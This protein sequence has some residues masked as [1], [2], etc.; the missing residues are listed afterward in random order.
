MG[1]NCGGDVAGLRPLTC[2][3]VVEWLRPRTTISFFSFVTLLGR[4]LG[5]GRRIFLVLLLL[6]LG[7]EFKAVMSLWSLGV[8]P[9]PP[10]S[11]ARLPL[12]PQG[13][14]FHAFI[15]ATCSLLLKFRHW[16]PRHCLSALAVRNAACNKTNGQGCH[17]DQA[18]TFPGIGP[19]C[20]ATSKSNS[21]NMRF[22]L[23]PSSPWHERSHSKVVHHGRFA[24]TRA[25]SKMSAPK[26][27]AF[28]VIFPV[29]S[30]QHSLPFPKMLPAA[31]KPS[32]G[33]KTA[34]LSKSPFCG[35]RD[36]NRQGCALLPLHAKTLKAQ[37]G[38]V[39]PSNIGF[40]FTLRC[41]HQS[42][43]GSGGGRVALRGVIRLL[44]LSPSGDFDEHGT[45]Q[46]PEKRR[47]MQCSIVWMMW[48]GKKRNLGLLMS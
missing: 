38:D 18:D 16:C 28:R 29:T 47:W 41:F 22:Q 2:L 5:M 40:L 10:L 13:C 39:Y 36:V 32:G 46:R 25:T 17:R 9:S 7:W 6:L 43:L 23:P 4:G 8:A 27:T 42:C 30:V 48:P 11:I 19:R 21:E 26:T 15:P 35:P 45:A 14:I 3:R 1:A 24:S 12:L 20:L 31:S 33:E 44:A 34:R 37:A